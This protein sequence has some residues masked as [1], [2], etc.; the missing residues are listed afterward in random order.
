MREGAAVARR[1]FQRAESG[2]ADSRPAPISAALAALVILALMAWP[3]TAAAA[4][5]N[6]AALQVALHAR[7]L[8]GGTVDGVVGPLTR[9]AVRRFQARRGLAVDGIAGPQTRRALG[10]RGRPGLGRRVMSGGDRGWDVAA[11]QFMLARHGF[12]SGAF[13]GRLGP[14]SDAAVRRFQAWAGLGADGLAGTATLAALR[15]SPPRSPLRF[16]APVPGSVGDRF[17]PRGAAFHAG[18]D[19]PVGAGTPIGAAGRG[20][21]QSVGLDAGYGKFVV[22]A[23]RAG[24]TSL[25]AHL[26]RIQVSRGEC[27]AT[28][29]RIGTVGSTGNATGPHLHFELRL[30]GAAIDPLTG[31]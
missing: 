12:P 10:W 1:L 9:D 20:C 17:G 15:R 24:M 11:L 8:Y 6:V 2:S 19:F 30:R 16:A 21:V 5:A 31:L 22:V 7:D 4:R 28:G 29:A 25:Y 3:A 18:V 13:D 14:R 23:H 27:L 26:A